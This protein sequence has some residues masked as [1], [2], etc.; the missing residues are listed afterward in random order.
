MP[1]RSRA[2]MRISFAGGGTDVPPY[3]DEHGG[4][5]VSGAIRLYAHTTLAPTGNREIVITSGDLLQTRRFASQESMTSNKDMDLL[6]AAVRGMNTKGRGVDVSFFT[7]VPPASGLGGSASAFVSLVGAFDGLDGRGMSRHGMAETALRLEREEL[8]VAGGKQDQYAAAYGGLNGITFG[9]DNVRVT[10]L[11]VDEQT[12]LDLEQ[13]LLLVYTGGRSIGSGSDIIKDQR[14]ATDEFHK[15][16]RIA[17]SARDALESGNLI[18]LGELLHEGWE[19]KKRFSAKI[20]NRH[21]DDLYRH[22]RDNGVLGGK[23]TGAG[24]GGFMLF[25]CGPGKRPLLARDLKRKGFETMTVSFD[26]EGLKT[27]ET[28]YV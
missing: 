19:T 9:K 14:G 10:P 25:L 28:A 1:I 12:R 20:S 17:F 4:Y 24:G 21:L 5:V 16:K 6:K 13:H 18:R 27:W 11:R 8:K 26:Y 2:P 7:E 23:V 3:C 22:A 15:T